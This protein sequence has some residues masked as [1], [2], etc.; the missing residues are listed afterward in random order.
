MKK[1]ITKIIHKL[2]KENYQLDDS[3]GTTDLLII[4]W[5]RVF[6]V[7]RGIIL[8]L[9]LKKSTGIIFLGKRTKIKHKHKITAGK[10][11]TIGDYVEINALSKQGVSLGNNVT[12]LKNTIIEC[13]GVIRELG[14]GLSIGDN[15]G[16]SQNCF[17]QVRGK[18]EIGSHVIFGPGVS[19]FSENH[20]FDNIEEYIINQGATRKGVSIQD[21]VWIGAGA[22]ILDGVTIG[23]N[24][25][26]AA[27]SVV[28]KDIPPFSIAG[29]VPAKV[30]KNRK[31]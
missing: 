15:V 2:G 8:K 6:C 24:A 29:G 20:N 3:L 18:I 9:F 5:E 23:E 30:I 17:I 11:L 27:G 10:T 22:T 16:I 7:L 14:E 25:I 28:N 4:I 19:L 12:I 1:I 26:I 21:G 31:G 13:T